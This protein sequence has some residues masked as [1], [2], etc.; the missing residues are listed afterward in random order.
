[1]VFILRVPVAVPDKAIFPFVET[2]PP[3]LTVR[4]VLNVIPEPLFMVTG[5]EKV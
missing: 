5:P 1:V 2:A 4:V 3:K